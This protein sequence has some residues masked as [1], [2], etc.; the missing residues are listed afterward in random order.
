MLNL[1]NDVRNH[2]NDIGKY[3]LLISIRDLTPFV[4]NKLISYFA[5]RIIIY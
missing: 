2:I 3:K 5:N 1:H 4:M